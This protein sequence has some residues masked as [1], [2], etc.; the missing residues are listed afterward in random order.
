MTEGSEHLHFFFGII[1]FTTFFSTSTAYLNLFV[2][3]PYSLLAN[4][5]EPFHCHLGQTL[6]S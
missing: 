5:I 6:Q 2:E 4:C 1:S 3:L